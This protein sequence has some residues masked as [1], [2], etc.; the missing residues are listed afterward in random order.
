[1]IELLISLTV[2]A[3]LITLAVPIYTDFSHKAQVSIGLRL[4]S[5]VQLAVSVYHSTH[6][7]FPISNLAANIADPDELGNRYVRSISITDK[8]TP[9]TIK[10]SYR[11]MGSVAEGDALLLV[12]TGYGE[13]VLWDCTSLTIIKSMLPAVCR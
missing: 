9:G 2:I 5:P 1:M 11:A 4:A 13:D 12:P 7:A 6:E 10:I 8:P 3:I